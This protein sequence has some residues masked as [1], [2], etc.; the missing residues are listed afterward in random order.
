[1]R[2][3]MHFTKEGALFLAHGGNCLLVNYESH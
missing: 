2:H 1:M 3:E